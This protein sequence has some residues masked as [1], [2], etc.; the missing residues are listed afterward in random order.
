MAYGRRIS[1]DAVR[2]AAFGSIAAGYAALGS[3]TTDNARI[4]M[5]YNTTDVDVYLSFD[6]VNNHIR[7]PSGGGETFDFSANKVRDDGLF[8]PVGTQIYQKRVSGAPTSG[9]VWVQLVYATGG[10]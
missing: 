1:F 9:A 5:A 7:L 6:G 2:E 4:F 3:S 8:L 10:V